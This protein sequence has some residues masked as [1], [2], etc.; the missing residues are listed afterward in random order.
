MSE[1]CKDDINACIGAFSSVDPDLSINKI[2]NAYIV[3][4][5]GRDE[6]ENWISK[7]VAVPNIEAACSLITSWSA[8]KLN[9]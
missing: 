4:I 9:G 8:M 3:K 2:A 7:S 6:N 1:C 5:D